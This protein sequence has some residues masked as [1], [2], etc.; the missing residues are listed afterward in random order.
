MVTEESIPLACNVCGRSLG[1]LSP[2]LGDGSDPSYRTYSCVPSEEPPSLYVPARQYHSDRL[3]PTLNDREQP[4][5]QS[6]ARAPTAACSSPAS[7][8]LTHCRGRERK[9]TV[10]AGAH[11]N[12][13]RDRGGGWW[14]FNTEGRD[15]VLRR[16]KA[17]RKRKGRDS[18]RLC[19]NAEGGSFFGFEDG[20]SHGLLQELLQMLT[21]LLLV[22]DRNEIIGR[23]RLLFRVR[24]HRCGFTASVADLSYPRYS[25]WL[26]VYFVVE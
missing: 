14:R 20:L 19:Y 25:L 16:P 9:F 23:R 10:G 11:W 15:D 17:G 18:R 6:G 26:R 4:S 12:G 5:C 1:L 21:I 24:F 8:C 22:H 3:F 13:R 2:T 7:W